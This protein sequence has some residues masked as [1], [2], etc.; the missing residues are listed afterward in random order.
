M[1][2]IFSYMLGRKSGGGSGGGGGSISLQDK[3]VTENG[4]TRTFEGTGYHD[5]NWGNKL[6]FFLMGINMIDLAKLE[7]IKSGRL[8]FNRSKTGHLYSMKVEPEAMALFEQYKGDKQ[9]G[10]K[11]P[12]IC[13]TYNRKGQQEAHRQPLSVPRSQKEAVLYPY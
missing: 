1:I 7:S 13:C 5:H 8:D 3:T 10:R 11:I 6:M 4:E 12:Y 9:L 2:D